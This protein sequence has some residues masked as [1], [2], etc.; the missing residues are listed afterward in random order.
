MGLAASLALAA[1]CSS[2]DAN[3]ETTSSGSGER[4]E[5]VDQR[6]ETVVLDGP[7]DT[8]AFTVIPAP[9][10]F[11]AIDRSYDRI[12][13]INQSTLVAN[14]G[15]M[16]ATI[17]PPSADSTVVS[18]SDFVPNVETLIELDP[19]VVVQWGD[20]GTDVVAPIE[21]AGFPVVC[22]VRTGTPRRSRVRSTSSSPASR[23]RSP[24]TGGR[25][26][27]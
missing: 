27:D 11:A 5:I 4:I 13:G 26:D 16:F 19:D 12:V 21:A 17:F 1:G 10:I 20:Q 18:G 14:R 22:A 9:S 3:E 23:T 2:R 8:I 7:A 25:R 15:G 24:P 6:G